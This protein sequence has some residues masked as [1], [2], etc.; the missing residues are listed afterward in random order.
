MYSARLPV[1]R[2]TK[3]TG[4]DSGPLV[5]AGGVCRKTIKSILAPREDKA[6]YFG[7]ERHLGWSRR[8]DPKALDWEQFLR[9]T[10][11]RGEQRLFS[12]PA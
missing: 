6:G 1:K 10:G 11:W 8:I 5:G 7:K 9:T 4:R 12:Q 2:P 3:T